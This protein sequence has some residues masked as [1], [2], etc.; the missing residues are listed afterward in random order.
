MNY[1]NFSQFLQL[2]L[3]DLQSVANIGTSLFL[4]GYE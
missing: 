1:L 2:M 3:N 4:I